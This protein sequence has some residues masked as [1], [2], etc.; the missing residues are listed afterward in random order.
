MSVIGV[1]LCRYRYAV[2]WVKEIECRKHLL[3]RLVF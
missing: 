3:R 2:Q 1:V